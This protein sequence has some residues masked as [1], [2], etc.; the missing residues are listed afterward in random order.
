VIP[1]VNVLGG[2]MAFTFGP[3]GTASGNESEHARNL[4]G[5][6]A[7]T[8]PGGPQAFIPGGGQT[9]PARRRRPLPVQRA[10]DNPLLRAQQRFLQE[11][12]AQRRPT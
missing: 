1:N 6:D 2:G 11:R 8:M 7:L 12:L 9:G 3:S 5:L 10:A 4:A